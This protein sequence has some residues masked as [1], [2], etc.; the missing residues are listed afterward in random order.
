[1]GE[2]V[3]VSSLTF[4]FAGAHVLVTGGT[5]GIGHAIA[6]AFAA[7]GADV[8]ITGTKPAAAD[9]DADLARSPTAS[10]A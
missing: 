5:S 2:G 8:T 9:Y 1:M 10:A 6:H 7:A 3:G 4:D